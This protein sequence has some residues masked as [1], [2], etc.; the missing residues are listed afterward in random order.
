[1]AGHRQANEAKATGLQ[2]YR[3]SI[4]EGLVIG[5]VMISIRTF[6]SS[7]SYGV[8]QGHRHLLGCNVEWGQD[9]LT[10]HRWIDATPRSEPV[11][12]FVDGLYDPQD[13]GLKCVILRNPDVLLELG[14]GNAL[15]N[16]WYAI[17]INELMKRR[18]FDGAGRSPDVHPNGNDFLSHVLHGT[19]PIG[20]LGS[21]IYL[22]H[23]SN[24][25]LRCLHI[26]TRSGA[27]L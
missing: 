23:V 7:L 15:P 5:A 3:C 26:D 27:P 25:G 13:L 9:L 21:T 14:H 18:L 17:G 4:V 16:G 1:M 12:V 2:R 6:P 22:Y 24:T 8:N 10:L 11:Y 20:K 19:V